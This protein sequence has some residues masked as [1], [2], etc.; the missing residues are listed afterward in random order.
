MGGIQIRFEEVVAEWVADDHKEN[1]EL[2]VIGRKVVGSVIQRDGYCIGVIY[3]DGENIVYAGAKIAM[4]KRV[5]E[6]AFD[7]V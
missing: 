5:E 3:R 1:V 6:G 4:M 2:Y 7:E